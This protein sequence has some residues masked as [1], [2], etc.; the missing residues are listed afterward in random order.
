[1]PRCV[2][3]DW[4]TPVPGW[5]WWFGKC[6]ITGRKISIRAR[7]EAVEERRERD[8][9]NAPAGTGAI[10]KKQGKESM[11][12]NDSKCQLSDAA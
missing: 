5:C 1:M 11:R 8:K 6:L 12:H 2:T 10:S 9:E 3:C 7:C 4:W